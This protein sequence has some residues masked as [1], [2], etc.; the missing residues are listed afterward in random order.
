MGIPPGEMQRGVTLRGYPLDSSATEKGLA[1]SLRM[2]ED[3][4]RNA[5]VDRSSMVGE[6]NSKWPKLRPSS[7]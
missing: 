4:R 2:E 3:K 5:V 6:E 1:I 7:E